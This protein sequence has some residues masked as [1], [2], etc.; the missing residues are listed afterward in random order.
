MEGQE[1][2][3]IGR[4]KGGFNSIRDCVILILVLYILI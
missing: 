2:M 3:D 1:A 4:E